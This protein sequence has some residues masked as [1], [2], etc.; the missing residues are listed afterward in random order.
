[1]IPCIVVSPEFS[2][3]IILFKII[4][5]PDILALQRFI[6]LISDIDFI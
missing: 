6:Y 1:M 2:F 5:K 4:D 3:D